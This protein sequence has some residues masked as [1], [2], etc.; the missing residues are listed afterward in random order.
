MAKPIYHVVYI[1]C[2]SC[3]QNNMAW[4]RRAYKWIINRQ[5]VYELA[6]WNAQ[7]F[8]FTK[9]KLQA[10]QST[11]LHPCNKLLRRSLYFTMRQWLYCA[12][13]ITTVCLRENER[14]QQIVK[15]ITGFHNLFLR[16][17]NLSVVLNLESAVSLL[18]QNDIIDSETFTTTYDDRGC[19][20]LL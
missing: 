16:F 6:I 3:V 19:L 1:I 14:E 9:K 5:I 2:I 17:H 12:F 11:T 7:D 20:S 18:L 15:F 4:F 10:K 13:K 8:T